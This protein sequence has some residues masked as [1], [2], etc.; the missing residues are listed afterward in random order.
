MPSLID[1]S[2][3]D[4]F[5]SNYCPLHNHSVWSLLDGMVRVE[6]M[7]LRAKELGMKSLALTEHGNMYS[8]IE[9]YKTCKKHGI[10]PI[11]GCEVYVTKDRT[12]KDKKELDRLVQED[13]AWLAYKS[14]RRRKKPKRK[15]KGEENTS[16]EPEY[17]IVDAWSNCHLVLLAKNQKG[18][19]NLLNIVSD[20]NLNGFYYKPLTDMS[21]LRKYGE[22]IV[23]LSACLGGEIPKLIQHGDLEKAKNLAIEYTEVFDDF[24][25]EIQPGQTPEQILVNEALK[26]MSKELDI[27]LVCTSDTHYLYEE[28]SKI[29]DTLLAVQTGKKVDDPDRM[30]FPEMIY[31]FKSEEEMR[32]DGMPDE[33]IK[34]TGIIAES[35]NVKIPL[36]KLFVPDIEVP[37]GYNTDTYLSKLCYDSLFE[38]VLTKGVDVKA[39]KE[40][41][42]FELSVIQ[43][44]E[45]SGY[46]LIVRDFIKWANSNGIITGPGRGSAAG[47]LVSYLVG[48]TKLDP[49][50]HGLLFQRFLNPERM[51]YPDCLVA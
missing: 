6:D 41:L 46:F 31:W 30:R 14:Q 13:E 5:I 38:M 11:I 28:D 42:R 1:K 19:E 29:H 32:K 4:N 16:T 15:K 9:F 43:E 7:V 26:C 44:K 25:L 40:R 45:L 47:S 36:D 48:I 12:L 33:A 20:A 39:Y 37:E 49:I 51:S 50:K 22:G 2:L 34:N 10:K 35:C 23:A 21:V 17:Q 3:I 8:T 27:P 24:Y 18:Y